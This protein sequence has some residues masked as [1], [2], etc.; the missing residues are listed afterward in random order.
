MKSFFVT[1]LLVGSVGGIVL[2]KPNPLKSKHYLRNLVN[3]TPAVALDEPICGVPSSAY[4]SDDPNDSDCYD[5]NMYKT[6]CAT[7]CDGIRSLFNIIVDAWTLDPKYENCS[8]AVIDVILQ[9]N[10]VANLTQAQADEIGVDMTCA[11]EGEF[12]D[13]TNDQQ[14][15]APADQAPADAPADEE[16]AFIAPEIV[17]LA[18]VASFALVLLATSTYQRVSASNKAKKVE[19]EKAP[20]ISGLLF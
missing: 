14:A 17:V 2:G 19:K 8:T 18:C 12:I 9:Q 1:V 6:A 5:M 13:A 3:A 10:V 4:T 11:V 16:S 7:N 20:L 15:P